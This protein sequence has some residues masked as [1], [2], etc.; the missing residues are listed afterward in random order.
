M[1]CHILPPLLPSPVKGGA[2]PKKV[3]TD[4]KLIARVPKPLLLRFKVECV[5]RETTIQAATQEA[6]EAWLKVKP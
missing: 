3:N 2:M 5:R 6:I 4:P 1:T